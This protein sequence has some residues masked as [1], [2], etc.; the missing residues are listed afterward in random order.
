MTAPFVAANLF[1]R[2][3]LAKQV[4]IAGVNY[5]QP[6]PAGTNPVRAAGI[7]HRSG[8]TSADKL[9][10]PGVPTSLTDAGASGGSTLLTTNYYISVAAFNR[11]GPTPSCAVQGPQAITAGHIFQA[12]LAQVAGADG[13]DV[14][15][16]SSSTAPAWVARITEVQRAAGCTVT[17]VG[18]VTGT[19]PGAGKINIL[20]PGT[21]LGSNVNP[22]LVNNAYT[23]AAPT[24]VNCAG[25]QRAHIHIALAVTD[26]RSMPTLSIIPF[27]QDQ[28]SPGDWFSGGIQTLALLADFG[29]CL[30]QDF[31]IDVDGS[32]NM[33]VLVDTLAGQGAAVNVWVELM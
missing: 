32:T 5:N 9:L 14:F 28:L 19:S 29:Q 11:W 16:S 31:E 22:F 18:T 10:T 23:P 8:V 24:P 4:A 25:Y 17:A 7:A 26:L 1:G 21:G 2:P 30:E 27:F 12:T 20:I 33:V 13:Y 3:F 15:M 6:A